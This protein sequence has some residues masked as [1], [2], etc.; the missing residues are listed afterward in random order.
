LFG[1]WST[2]SSKDEM[3]NEISAYAHSDYSTPTKA[4]KFPYSDVKSWIG[5]GCNKKRTWAYIGFTK[6]PNILN[7]STHD[8]YYEIETRIKF[9]KNVGSETLTQDWGSEFLHFYYD[10]KIIE[11]IKNSNNMLLELQWYGNGNKY[12]NY[13]LSG[14]TKAINEALK[15]CG[16]KY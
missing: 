9:D 8:G 15:K 14:S 13:S 1:S 10:D 7:T 11:K 3:T 12:F 6:S 5:V 2:T 4:M 16:Y